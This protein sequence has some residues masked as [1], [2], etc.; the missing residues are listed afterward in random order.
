MAAS[1]WRIFNDKTFGNS[2]V[3]TYSVGGI[4]DLY[5][6]TGDKPDD[7]IKSYQ[8]IVGKPALMP[9]WALGWH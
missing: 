3:E 1:D 5:I 8:K 6:V 7:V 4:G 2:I 9:Q